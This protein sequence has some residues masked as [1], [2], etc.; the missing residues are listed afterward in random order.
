MGFAD[1]KEPWWQA[2]K[3]VFFLFYYVKHYMLTYCT[4]CLK[5]SFTYCKGKLGCQIKLNELCYLIHS[6]HLLITH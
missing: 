3:T 2:L 6:H 4:Y 5:V 1:K